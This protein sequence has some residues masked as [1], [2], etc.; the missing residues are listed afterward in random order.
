MACQKYA[1][2]GGMMHE[3]KSQ[4]IGK[5]PS[6]HHFHTTVRQHAEALT[7]RWLTCSYLFSW[8]SYYGYIGTSPTLKLW[9]MQ[10]TE[11]SQLCMSGQAGNSCI[12]LE[13]SVTHIRPC[14]MATDPT[15][16]HSTDLTGSTQ[17]VTYRACCKRIQLES[18]LLSAV[19]SMVMV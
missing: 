5:A 10:H 11:G 8:V 2:K 18:S 19:S 14:H 12:A 6:L 17:E 9:A 15:D 4:C 16:I 7:C 3:S 13:T 1:N